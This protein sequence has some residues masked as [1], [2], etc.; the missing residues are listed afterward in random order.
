MKN[1]IKLFVSITLL[2]ASVCHADIQSKKK[3]TI[4][5]RASGRIDSKKTPNS[6]R[7]LKDVLKSRYV[8]SCS[9]LIPFHEFFDRMHKYN[10]EHYR[11][12]VAKEG[13]VGYKIWYD[14]QEGKGKFSAEREWD[15]KVITCDWD[16]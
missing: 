16:R 13:V 4:T 1:M 14:L 2:C 5:L 7:V 10:E 8:Y 12:Y 6:W 9:E 11:E 15:Y 3:E